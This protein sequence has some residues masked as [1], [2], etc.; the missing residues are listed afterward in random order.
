MKKTI[1]ILLM[2][3]LFACQS[4]AQKRDTVFYYMKIHGGIVKTADSAEFVRVVVSPEKEDKSGLFTVTDVYRNGKKKTSG[5]SLT[6]TPFPRWDG[7]VIS[8]YPN[9]HRES[10][11]NYE[12]GFL[13]GQSIKYYPNGQLYTITK[14]ESRQLALVE[15]H[16]TTGKVSAENGNGTWLD[17]NNDYTILYQQGPIVNGVR[18]GNWVKFIDGKEFPFE[19]RDGKVVVTVNYNLTGEIV[20]QPDTPPSIPDN[21]DAFLQ[22]VSNSTRYPGIARE[23]SLTGVVWVTFVVEKDGSL[24]DVKVSKSAS[25]SMD[26]EV[27]R[28]VRASPVRWM[29]AFLNGKAVRSL[30]NFAVCFYLTGTPPIQPPPGSVIITANGVGR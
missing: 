2:L 15:C 29:P 18:Q 12:N 21:K 25:K 8:Y 23:N 3:P 4:K 22:F 20:P 10:I 30:Y 14:T 19:Y 27:V 6:P 26:D 17:F 5:K 11:T 24:S 7:P 1:F 28:V 13:S 9:G 16:D